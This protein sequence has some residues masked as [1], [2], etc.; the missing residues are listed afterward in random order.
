MD[1]NLDYRL[2]QKLIFNLGLDKPNE[3]DPVCMYI[4]NLLV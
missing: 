4:S 1:W 2:N 3:Q